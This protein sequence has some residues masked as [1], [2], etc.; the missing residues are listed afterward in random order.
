MSERPQWS[1]RDEQRVREWL[2][3]LLRFAITRDAIDGAAAET[4]AG[5][6]DAAA[7]QG[8]PSFNYF[9]RTTREVC[10]AIADPR[11]EHNSLILQKFVTQIEDRRLKAAFRACLELPDN[12]APRPRRRAAWRERQDLWRGLPKR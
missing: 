3:L 12:S 6:L 5:P 10:K 1:A 8:T 11:N 2:L 4:A 9:V 7:F